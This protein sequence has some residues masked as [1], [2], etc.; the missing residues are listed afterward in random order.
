MNLYLGQ[1]EWYT[2]VDEKLQRS[3]WRPPG[4]NAT[5][6]IDLRSLAQCAKPGG[7]PEG[8]GL[9]V[10]NTEQS[11]PL[12]Q[13]NL[14]TDLERNITITDRSGLETF[15][16]KRV[17]SNK[18]SDVIEELLVVHYDIKNGWKPLTGSL[19]SGIKIYLGGIIVSEAV[20]EG[21]NATIAVF[22][23]DYIRN[24]MDYS[25][26]DL[27][28]WTGYMMWSLWGRMSDSLAQELLPDPY[29]SDGWL[30]PH[31]TI[32]DNFNRADSTSLGSSSEG[33]SWTETQGNIDIVTNR[34]QARA[35]GVQSARAESSL[36]SDAHLSQCVATHSGASS[37]KCGVA[38]RFSAS[39][40][41]YYKY[42]ARPATATVQHE[43][44]K[45]VTGT[46][47]SL[48][49]QTGNAFSSG[50]TIKCDVDSSNLI[51]GLVNGV[52]RISGTDTS[53]TGNL[54]TGIA[55][56]ENV[57]DR[58][59]WDDFLAEDLTVPSAVAPGHQTL[60]GVGV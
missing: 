51:R 50:D 3:Y 52:L 27:R 28:R 58:I 44:I 11:S 21:H 40:T 31:T 14:G 41:T 7:I 19:R 24:R 1:W 29:K 16:G 48:F 20:P 8:Y 33:W 42:Q 56:E 25:L 45:V 10:Y 36:S 13:Y 2:E 47:T 53:I 30:P 39:A 32:T 60:L 4:G 9:F 54:R 49:T 35:V 46:E 37:N 55:G 59:Q 43:I 18:L 12:L 34:A 15:L 23:D 38:V 22:Q 26:E 5:G 17:L 57:A 6:V